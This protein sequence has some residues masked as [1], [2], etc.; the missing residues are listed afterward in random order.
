MKQVHLSVPGNLFIEKTIKKITYK[1]YI[2][3][4]KFRT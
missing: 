2:T 1:V 3:E 4:E